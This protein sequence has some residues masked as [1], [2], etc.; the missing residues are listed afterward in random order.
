ML[1][2]N[3]SHYVIAVLIKDYERHSFQRLSYCMSIIPQY[4]E[5]RLSQRSRTMCYTFKGSF[6]GT[7]GTRHIYSISI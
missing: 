1:I 5:K 3:Q 6:A 7:P 4:K 2:Q